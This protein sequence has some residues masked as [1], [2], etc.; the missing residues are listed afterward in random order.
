MLSPPIYS[1]LA[2]LMMLPVRANVDTCTPFTYR[3]IVELSY[4]KARCDQVVGVECRADAK[5]SQA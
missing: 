5:I 4:V 3:R 1:G 2:E